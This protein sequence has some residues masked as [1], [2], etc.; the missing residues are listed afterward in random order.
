LKISSKQKQT[1]DLCGGEKTEY[2]DCREIA[3]D[4]CY[5][6]AKECITFNT[7]AHVLDFFIKF[8]SSAF[9]PPHT[10]S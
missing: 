6:L 7:I 4:H 5:S 10:S 8:S 1:I 9:P 3:N 2:M